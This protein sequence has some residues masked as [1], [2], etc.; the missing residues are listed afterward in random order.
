M[1]ITTAGQCETLLT[2]RMPSGLHAPRGGKLNMALRGAMLCLALGLGAVSLPAVAESR[3]VI[4]V[5]PPAMQ[6]EEVPAAR[7]GYLWAPGYWRWQKRQ[8]V[9]V[10]GHWIGERRGQRYE[11]PR[12]EQ[13]GH[14]YEFAPGRWQREAGR[15][16]PDSMRG[17]QRRGEQR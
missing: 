5:A 2:T 6:F 7:A 10:K 14:R 8:H 11:S 9:W 12:W 13:R 3:V 1:K 4:R 16:A 15:H 17:G